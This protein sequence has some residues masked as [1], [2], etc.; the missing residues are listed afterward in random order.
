MTAPT[1]LPPVQGYYQ[2]SSSV[3]PTRQTHRQMAQADA[4]EEDYDDYY[5]EDDDENGVESQ[6][7]A[8]KEAGDDFHIPDSQLIQE[9]PYGNAVNV[10]GKSTLTYAPPA[11]K[12]T[13]PQGPA[14]YLPH[15]GTPSMYSPPAAIPGMPGPGY[16]SSPEQPGF[17]QSATKPGLG[18]MMQGVVQTIGQH[19][20]Q[21]AANQQSLVTVAPN[22][23]LPHPGQ[24]IPQTVGAGS[25]LI[26]QVNILKDV[27][28]T[29]ATNFPMSMPDATTVGANMAGFPLTTTV[30]NI[31]V[32]TTPQKSPVKSDHNVSGHDEEGFVSGEDGPGFQEPQFEPIVQLPEQVDLK[33]GEEGYIVLFS[34]R[35]KLFRF[36]EKQWKERGLGVIKILH[37]EENHQ[38]RLVMRREQV[39]KVCANHYIKPDMM[40]DYKEKDAHSKD[41]K[42]LTWKAVDHSDDEARLE[43]FACKFKTA[44][45]AAD[46]KNKFEHA[47]SI[48][49]EGSDDTAP[50]TTDS[51]AKP[52][53]SDSATSQVTP[54]QPAVVDRHSGFGTSQFGSTSTAASDLLKS[55]ATAAA[56]QL[57]NTQTFGGFSF[58]STPVIVQDKPKDD[59]NTAT[60]TGSTAGEAKT[61]PKN[62]P[63]ASFSFSSPASEYGT[64]ASKPESTPTSTGGIFGSFAKTGSSFASIAA[65]GENNT[66]LANK[67]IET[68]GFTPKAIFGSP[69][70]TSPTKGDDDH[71]TEDYEPDVDFAPIVTLPEV[72]D[73][74]TGEEEEKK[75]FGERAKLYRHDPESKAWKERG[76]GEI[77]IMSNTK[78]MKYRIIMR[79]EQVLKV[80]A[81]H[82]ITKQMKLDPMMNSNVAFCYLANDFAEEEAKAE[83]LAVKFKNVDI[84][85]NFKGIFEDCQAKLTS[86]NNT[87]TTA[88][89]RNITSDDLTNL[90]EN[91]GKP[92]N[93]QSS[94][95]ALP[96]SS[97]SSEASLSSMF[98]AKGDE[99]DCTGCYVRNT[100]DVAKC[101]ACNAPKPGSE[102]SKTPK[103]GKTPKVPDSQVTSTL[104]SNS[105]EN[106]LANMFVAK[107]G[108]WDCETCY[109]RNKGDVKICAACSTLKPGCDAEQESN[110][111]STTSTFQIGANG[112]FN[113][114]GSA[115]ISGNASFG[116][117]FVAGSKPAA[118]SSAAPSGGFAFVSSAQTQPVAPAVK[119]EDKKPTT[120]GYKFASNTEQPTTTTLPPA[121]GGFKFGSS[122]LAGSGGFSFGNT[123]AASSE[124]TPSEPEVSS[125]EPD[126]M[127][128]S[129]D[130]KTSKFGSST[131]N[132]SLTP[133]TTP[134]KPGQP[135]PKS[136]KTPQ[137]PEGDYYVNK[138]GE[139][140]HIYFEPVV[141]LPDNVVV[142]TGEE[143]EDVLYCHRAKLFRFDSKEWKERGLGDIKLLQNKSSKKIRLLM[144]REKV[145]KICLN[146]IIAPDMKLETMASNPGKTWTW[147][148]MDFAEDEQKHERFA[149][150]FKS[151]EVASEFKAAFDAARDGEEIPTQT[152]RAADRSEAKKEA[153]P[154][155]YESPFKSDVSKDTSSSTGF[156]F[157]NMS[158]TG[159]AFSFGKSAFGSGAS[160]FGGGAAPSSTGGEKFTF[161]QASPA[162]AGKPEADKPTPTP[163]NQSPGGSSILAKLLT[164]EQSAMEG[165]FMLQILN[166]VLALSCHANL[167]VIIISIISF[168]IRNMHCY[169]RNWDKYIIGGSSWPCENNRFIFQ[170]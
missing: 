57:S 14:G 123:P 81:N 63:F 134:Q 153:T 132:F 26:H 162:P 45:V 136:P 79:R 9:W 20:N 160:V 2:Q 100:G 23:N 49:V 78:T 135:G 142:K 115:A 170:N 42:V 66:G 39:H 158:T 70:V 85:H 147:H 74:K 11:G 105:S 80:C 36:T 68:K 168:L 22:V 29:V 71:V 19:I 152:K 102:P 97:A 27:S 15:W 90:A 92:T 129:T 13:M 43:Q 127:A 163:S 8:D 52:T 118:P 37:K 67:P 106:S 35:A 88:P 54:V 157:G 4:A 122:A 40:I 165:R 41:D 125:T 146:H 1:A 120:T 61:P 34:H 58:T 156:S 154:K 84:A 76:I 93:E 108:E 89:P 7:A 65:S 59:K 169:Y 44:D 139:D 69:A 101:V 103:L 12:P 25:P 110:V 140:D 75:L 141:K 53:A 155:K 24:V 114:G 50:D 51:V 159:S 96:T 148:A 144:R 113:F 109:V 95:G 99:W 77:K 164:G 48:A 55:M 5:I 130:K 116:N 151:E 86:P 46:F 18:L 112:G 56:G 28:T 150:K 124:T 17:P 166:T 143:H 38:V 87:S 167:D 94:L 107:G 47:V 73:L 121:T 137:S 72:K 10:E 21:Q 3:G 111:S 104:A 98:Q 145:L 82:Y 60:T 128:E 91:A 62:N 161:G 83:F 30:S 131:F 33:T 6:A 133:T 16:F 126:S 32:V 119:T 138:D 149:I 117:Q 64:P 31:H